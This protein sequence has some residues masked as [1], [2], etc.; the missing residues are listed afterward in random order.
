MAMVC[1]IPWGLRLRYK[2]RAMRRGPDSGFFSLA[3]GLSSYELNLSLSPLCHA[4]FVCPRYGTPVPVL[5]R[6]NNSKAFACWLRDRFML[7]GTSIAHKTLYWPALWNVSR[8][9]RAAK[10]LLSEPNQMNLGLGIPLPK[11]GSVAELPRP[12]WSTRYLGLELKISRSIFYTVWQQLSLISTIVTLVK[13]T[14]IPRVVS[15]LYTWVDHLA[16]FMPRRPS[17]GGRS[18]S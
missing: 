9:S 7:Q 10:L 8:C 6:Y 13:L 3:L 12:C 1:S 18:L 15:T 2:K 14:F 16:D 17:I 4:R 5:E 11:R